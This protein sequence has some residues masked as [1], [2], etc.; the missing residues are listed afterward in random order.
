MTQASKL[1]NKIVNS[2]NAYRKIEDKWNVWRRRGPTL[3]LLLKLTD[4]LTP[5]TRVVEALPGLQQ[6]W[7]RLEVCIMEDFM[8]LQWDFFSSIHRLLDLGSW[9]L[10]EVSCDVQA[11]TLGSFVFC[12]VTNWRCVHVVIYT[13][14]GSA[15]WF[16]SVLTVHIGLFAE[17]WT[18]CSFK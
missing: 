17:V 1:L 14:T 11:Q 13:N 8:E 5:F 6:N 18:S 10:N 3:L 4:S 7:S 9:A 16:W 15:V 12:W 2:S